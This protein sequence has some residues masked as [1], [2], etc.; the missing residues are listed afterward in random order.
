MSD[1]VAMRCVPV[2][3][4]VWDGFEDA[5]IKWLE[6]RLGDKDKPNE[7]RF[8][9]AEVNDFTVFADIEYTGSILESGCRCGGCRESGYSVVLDNGCGDQYSVLDR[10][11]EADLE[12]DDHSGEFDYEVRRLAWKAALSIRIR[13]SQED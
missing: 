11:S 8:P 12:Q 2:H 10:Q 1:T 6:T 7:R 5:P 3:I 13:E 9:L 4:P